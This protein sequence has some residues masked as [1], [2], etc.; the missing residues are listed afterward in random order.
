VVN[1]DWLGKAFPYL[2]VTVRSK[3]TTVKASASWATNS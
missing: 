1:G 3:R 2:A